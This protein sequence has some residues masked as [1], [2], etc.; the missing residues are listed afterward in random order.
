MGFRNEIRSETTI[1]GTA[2]EDGSERGG[3][4]GFA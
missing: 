1:E 4:E 2:D 3:A